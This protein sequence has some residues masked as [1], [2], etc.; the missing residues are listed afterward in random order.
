M[1]FSIET[2]SQKEIA[3]GPVQLLIAE[4]KKTRKETPRLSILALLG[5]TAAMHGESS[6]C[7]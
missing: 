7:C 4:A 3:R 6:P 1:V 2:N 5:E